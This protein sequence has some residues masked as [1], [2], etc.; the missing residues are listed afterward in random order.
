VLLFASAFVLSAIAWVGQMAG[1]GRSWAD[2]SWP[3]LT[4]EALAVAAALTMPLLV[5]GH[6]GRRAL[7]WGLGAA[8]MTSG[9][10]LANGSTTRILL[11]WSF[12]LAGYLPSLVYG[13]AVGAVVYVLVALRRKGDR[14]LAWGLA[15]LFMGGIGL[16]S[17]YQSALVLAGLTVLGPAT[18][19]PGR[20]SWRGSRTA[21]SV[22]A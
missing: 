5:D 13:A 11:L 21:V 6:G 2:A 20:G 14:T 16:H 8:L 9:A 19:G 15:F 17:S 12:G 7:A 4:A 18:S 10:L 1:A 3:A 22:E